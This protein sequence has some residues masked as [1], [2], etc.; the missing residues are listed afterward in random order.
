MSALWQSFTR[1]LWRTESAPVRVHVK[2]LTWWA[3]PDY[4]DE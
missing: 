2:S 1:W 4:D 3:N